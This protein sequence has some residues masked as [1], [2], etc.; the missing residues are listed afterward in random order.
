[1]PNSIEQGI[2]IY[3]SFIAGRQNIQY[4]DIKD[5]DVLIEDTSAMSSRYFKIVKMPNQF[6]GGKN[7]LFLLGDSEYLEKDTEILI[8]VLDANGDNIFVETTEYGPDRLWDQQYAQTIA[9]AKGGKRCVAIWLQSDAAPGIGRILVAGIAAKTP[10]GKTIQGNPNINISKYADRYNVRWSKDIVIEPFRPNSSEL[11]YLDYDRKKYSTLSG[12]NSISASMYEAT[13]SYNYITSD[14][15]TTLNTNLYYSMSSPYRNFQSELEV[16][17]GPNPVAGQRIPGWKEV[18]DN[19]GKNMIRI[20]VDT[21]SGRQIGYVD[22]Q[23]TFVW[24]SQLDAATKNVSQSL[25]TPLANYNTNGAGINVQV[26]NIQELTNAGIISAYGFAIDGRDM[27]KL[28]ASHSFWSP[29]TSQ[30]VGNYLYAHMYPNGQYHVNGDSETLDDF[31]FYNY[32]GFNINGNLSFGP[33]GGYPLSQ[34]TQ[35]GT[36]WTDFSKPSN[37]NAINTVGDRGWHSDGSG[38]FTTGENA[39]NGIGQV[40]GIVNDIAYVTTGLIHEFYG[41]IM[42]ESTCAPIW[43]RLSASNYSSGGGSS[44]LA[45]GFRE[46]YSHSVDAPT[47]VGPSPTATVG[48]SSNDPY[49][50]ALSF[51]RAISPYAVGVGGQQMHIEYIDATYNFGP[52]VYEN[53]P[54]KYTFYN[55]TQKIVHGIFEYNDDGT[56]D[57]QNVGF[58]NDGEGD[59]GLNPMQGQW[60]VIGQ[61]MF[62]KWML[63]YKPQFDY[64]TIPFRGYIEPNPALHN[65]TEVTICPHPWSFMFTR[66]V[67]VHSDEFAD[68]YTD[69]HENGQAVFSPGMPFFDGEM[70]FTGMAQ[71]LSL[72]GTPIGPG[73]GGV[74][75]PWDPPYPPPPPPPPQGLSNPKILLPPFLTFIFY[76]TPTSD[77]TFAN[78]FFIGDSNGC[79]PGIDTSNPQTFLSDHV[80]QTGNSTA[81]YSYHQFDYISF[82]N[83]WI[84]SGVHVSMSYAQQPQRYEV[85]NIVSYLNFRL[86]NFQ[87][88]TGDVYKLKVYK[89]P[90]SGIKSWEFM[91]EVVV[92]RIELLVSESASRPIS[93]IGYFDQ[94]ETIDNNWYTGSGTYLTHFFP[95]TDDSGNP[96]PISTSISEYQINWLGPSNGNY[97]YSAEQNPNGNYPPFPTASISDSVVLGS[98]LLGNGEELVSQSWDNVTATFHPEEGNGLLYY[99][100]GY[101]DFSPPLNSP[102]GNLKPGKARS[103]YDFHHKDGILLSTE[104]TYE[105]SFIANGKQYAAFQT[106]S[107]GAPT[108]HNPPCLHVYMSGSSFPDQHPADPLYEHNFGRYVRSYFIH[109]DQASDGQ[110]KSF[111]KQYAFFRTNEAASNN[112]VR[113]I[114][115]GGSWL[116]SE[117]SIKDVEQTGFTPS[118]FGFQVKLGTEQF[119]EFMD[120]KLEMYNW[121]GEKANKDLYLP[122]YYIQ[123]GNTWT[124]NLNNV[125]V[126]QTVYDNVPYDSFLTGDVAMDDGGITIFGNDPNGPGNGLG[127]AT[128]IG[129]NG[130]PY[131]VK[132]IG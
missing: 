99:P 11:I 100:D 106:G 110:L 126:G 83:E 7:A 32:Q 5:M 124:N 29:N 75:N 108:G 6:E 97:V 79:Q 131:N 64:Q 84:N 88:I 46:V 57:P 70:G 13:W 101:G 58:I 129:D 67:L 98:I 117:I 85:N 1:M 36:G 60:N 53:G 122:N 120:F 130:S 89:R 115:T 21:G 93:P 22:P 66:S 125:N 82:M 114:I 19:T 87:P 95:D 25:P 33:V 31:Y 118:D 94:Q 51:N 44:H 41:N 77:S 30:S 61:E 127:D 123:G 28:M 112:R 18:T 102:M 63:W 34:S 2:D 71:G 24:G 55:S 56:N 12:S 62:Q 107:D 72:D 42:S 26:D 111:G 4:Y 65:K 9:D 38:Q 17:G 90:K 8:E 37:Y 39:N 69:A 73:G 52:S 40:T 109:P 48:T 121:Y 50:H 78:N 20:G 91:D 119:G 80:E 47:P 23:P 96:I 45:S 49:L 86:I 105:L 16:D 35:L 14:N 68:Y 128:I 104:R 15:N 43:T 74:G 92:E 132:P 59:G 54:S 10:E 27:W 81:G 116:L 103:F 3:Q 113:F 76:D